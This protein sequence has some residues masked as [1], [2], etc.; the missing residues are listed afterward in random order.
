M[1]NQTLII[2]GILVVMVLAYLA[3]TPF[4]IYRSS[5]GGSGD[6]DKAPYIYTASTNVDGATITIAGNCKSAGAGTLIDCRMLMWNYNTNAWDI[7]KT[8]SVSGGDKLGFSLVSPGAQ[9]YQGFTQC[10]ADVKETETL[11]DCEKYVTQV[12]NSYLWNNEFKL[13]F[14]STIEN[15][16]EFKI[17]SVTV[18][19]QE[20]APPA[21]EEQPSGG[22][23]VTTGKEIFI[24]RGEEEVTTTATTTGR[25]LPEM[26]QS[27]IEKIKGFFE[28][29]F[30]GGK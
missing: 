4:S 29:L 10:R 6:I 5:W 3:M 7:F 14:E 20:A 17:T 11:W 25:S 12:T 15:G 22:G 26:L 19:W 23:T 8:I 9:S 30:G 16:G 27:F 21:V 28:S 13:K 2:G 18:D 24:P 1:K